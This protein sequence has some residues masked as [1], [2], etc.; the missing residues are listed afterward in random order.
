MIL[1]QIPVDHGNVGLKLEQASKPILGRQKKK[2]GDT[3]Q[4]LRSPSAP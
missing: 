3:S 4:F 2:K 1:E